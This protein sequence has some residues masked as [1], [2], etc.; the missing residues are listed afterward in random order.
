MLGNLIAQGGNLGRDA[1]FATVFGSNLTVDC[2][3]LATMVPVFIATVG[4]GAY[5]SAIVPL[6]ERIAHQGGALARRAVVARTL[7]VNGSIVLGV[8]AVL[9]IG[10]AW[11][12]RLLATR[13]PPPAAE[14]IAVF[15]WAALPMLALSC[16][17]S[18]ADGALQAEG[19][20]FAAAAGRAL[21]PLGMASASILLGPRYGLWAACAGGLAG[22]IAQCVLVVALLDG[23]R[24]VEARTKMARSDD[25]LLLAPF[26]FLAASISIQYVSPI[27]DQLMA[28]LLGPGAVSTLG[29]ANR[30][31]VGAG[32]L[33][34]A[35]VG[36][37]LLP[38]FTRLLAQRDG[39]ALEHYYLG[40][41]R[42][43]FWTGLLMTAALWLV[44]QPLVAVLYEHGEFSRGDTDAVARV[45]AV[46]A[47]QF[48]VL[49]PGVVAATLIAATRRNRI[50]LPLTVCTALVN[51]AGNLLLMRALGL[52]GI[53]LATVITYAVSLI[54][55]NVYLHR[56][57]VVSVPA[58]LAIEAVAGIAG[59]A[60]LANVI[61]ELGL[62]PGV[63]PTLPQIAGS[64]ALVTLLASVAFRLTRPV[65]VL[66]ARRE[67]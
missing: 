33:A 12:G 37:V 57:G 17:A 2:F 8:A 44:A 40:V 42:L 3:L 51:A 60:L 11:Y 58:R 46:L 25:V 18:L 56:R 7:K 14:L 30:L 43:T 31:A 35:A 45:L 62:R 5:R 21:P 27:V 61:L 24:L 48:P 65:L 34:A 52:A 36:P 6:L 50:F 15:T 4:T 20:F 55:M 49:L 38:L 16:W 29:Y 53:A 54:A 66:A 26:M 32:S 22:A 64:V 28:S 39:A 63:I 1:T 41:L 10:A 59:T 19:R 23:R 47:L 9:A 13:L 67:V